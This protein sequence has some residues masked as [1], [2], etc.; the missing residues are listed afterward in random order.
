M[1]SSQWAVPF[2]AGSSRAVGDLL[3]LRDE[4]LARSLPNHVAAD[5][6]LFQLKLAGFRDAADESLA[7]IEDRLREHAP[8]AL[9]PGAGCVVASR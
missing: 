5:V 4:H 1:V 9:E 2:T 8:R 7:R 6:P 3:W